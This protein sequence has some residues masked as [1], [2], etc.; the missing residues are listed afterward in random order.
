[1]CRR[2]LRLQP[3]ARLSSG[4][5]GHH[6]RGHTA[7]HAHQGNENHVVT[8]ADA[9]EESP[10]DIVFLHGHKIAPSHSKL[11]MPV[12]VFPGLRDERLLRRL[13]SVAECLLKSSL[14]ADKPKVQIPA[15]NHRSD[16][17]V[18]QKDQ[19]FQHALSRLP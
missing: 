18:T 8:V 11:A 10:Y 1:M 7:A 16:S 14:Q 17:T 19:T 2:R 5:S 4:C 3:L 9:A 15:D 13:L 12:I 6:L